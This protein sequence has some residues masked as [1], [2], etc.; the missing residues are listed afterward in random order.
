MTMI[1]LLDDLVDD[2]ESDEGFVSH[3]Y[4]DSEGYWTVAYGIMIDKR[5]GGGLTKPEGRYLLRNRALIAIDDLD[6]NVPWWRGMPDDAQRAL[7]N[8]CFNL[9]WP[10]LSGFKKMLAAMKAGD[11]QTAAREALDSRWAGQVGDRALRIAALIRG[12]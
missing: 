9:G 8:M 10:R 4:L 2:L 3:A 12:A 5:R 11:T 7:S 6:R 1:K